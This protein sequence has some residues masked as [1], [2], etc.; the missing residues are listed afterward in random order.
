MA[1]IVASEKV[2]E[3]LRNLHEVFIELANV[4]T[5]EY[6]QQVQEKVK[7]EAEAGKWSYATE[8]GIT[9]FLDIYRDEKLLGEG[10]MRDVARRVQAL[11][12]ELGYIPTDILNSVHI[13]GL[14]EENVKLLQPY[15]KEMA[16]LVRA[17]KV[18]LHDGLLEAEAK[19]HEYP[20]DEKKIYIAIG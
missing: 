10:L 14:E 7:A 19:W 15:V 13:A 1:V 3:S 9:V 16:E 4:K 11:R 20:L 12:K 5:A 2:C 17:K 18:Y 6:T 8:K